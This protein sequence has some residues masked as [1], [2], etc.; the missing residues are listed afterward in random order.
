[1]EG[2]DLVTEGAIMLNQVY[3]ILDETGCSPDSDS[4]V[5]RLCAMMLNADVVTFFIGGAVNEAH[6]SMI[7]RQAGVRPRIAVIQLISK[8]LRE[9][10][11]LVVE[12]KY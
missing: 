5:E 1:M 7:F 8:K 9:F 12:I 11:K 2:I 3:N 4:P 10:G 6:D